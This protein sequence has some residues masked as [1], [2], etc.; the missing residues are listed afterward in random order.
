MRPAPP[1]TKAA[2][3]GWS[4][5]AGPDCLDSASLEEVLAPVLE[6]LKLPRGLLAQMTGISSRRLYPAGSPVIRGG[7][8]AAQALLDRFPHLKQQI[9]LHFSTSVGRDFLEPSA[10]SSVSAQLELGPQVRNMDLGSACLGFV[11]AL[12]LAAH[13]IEFDRVRYVLVT[14]GENSRPLLENTLEF[15]L[16]NKVTVREFF[17]SFASLTLGSGGAAM[18]VGPA[19]EHP[20]APRIRGA[21]SLADTKSNDL[22]RGDFSAMVTDAAGLMTAGVRLAGETFRLG[23]ETYGWTPDCFDS[24]ICH[25]VSRANTDK[26]CRD[27]ELPAERVF[28]TYPDYG[29]MGPVAVPFS[30]DLAWE[31]GL[32]R[33][34]RRTALMGIGSGLACSMMEL[35]IPAE[36]AGFSES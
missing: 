27:L 1:F 32:I 19:S 11:D 33:P 5:H 17:R 18:L 23:R 22:C 34:G 9:D 21:V 8:L 35:D 7:F 13:L 4:R 16:E 3:A 6:R 10:A 15:L 14:A 12:E 20:A 36:P 2:L 30:F 24:I 25:Q 26:L 31:K 29:N 28:R